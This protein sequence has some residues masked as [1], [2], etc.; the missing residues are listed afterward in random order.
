MMTNTGVMVI[1]PALY[2]R[3]PYSTLRDGSRSRYYFDSCLRSIYWGYR[4]L[5]H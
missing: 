2:T 5:V 3:L 4:H 1:N